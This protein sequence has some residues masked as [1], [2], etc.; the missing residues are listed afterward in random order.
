VIDR[1]H[2]PAPETF[3]PEIFEAPVG[4]F[5]HIVKERDD[6][7]LIRP[8]PQ[9]HSDWMEHIRQPMALPLAAVGFDGNL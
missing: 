5:N 3:F 6:P 4:V 7:F 2:D 8:H 9:H 1:P